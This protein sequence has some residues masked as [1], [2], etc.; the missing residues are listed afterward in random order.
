MMRFDVKVGALQSARAD[1]KLAVG[2]VQ[3]TITVEGTAPLLTAD[4]ASIGSARLP[5]GDP[6]PAAERARR[7]G[8]A[9]AFAR[10]PT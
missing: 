3:E 8:A 2:A 5:R 10:E 9:G 1:F 6:P 7:A 4:D